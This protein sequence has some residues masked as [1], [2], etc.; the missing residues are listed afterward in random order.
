VAAER[1]PGAGLVGRELAAVGTSMVDNAGAGRG[2]FEQLVL[3]VWIGRLYLDRPPD[4]GRV[5][6]TPRLDLMASIWTAYGFVED[7][8]RFDGARTLSAGTPVFRTDNRLISLG[9][10]GYG[11]SSG[12]TAAGVVFLSDVPAY[13]EFWLPRVFAHERVHTLQMDQIFLKWTRPIER[14]AIGAIPGGERFL[15]YVD[16]NLSTEL[17]ML[18]TIP[19]PDHQTRP[20]EIE[21]IYLAQ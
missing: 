14:A 4:G 10:E 19:F 11:H 12:I 6:V 3:P 8:L 2:T 20:W 9:G 1:F 17:L 21:A 7:E 13:G 5:R 15:R 18:L 16:V